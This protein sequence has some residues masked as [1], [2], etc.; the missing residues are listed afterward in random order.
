MKNAS[1]HGSND[2]DSKSGR[3]PSGSHGKNTNR[4]RF[5][6]SSYDDEMNEI[7]QDEGSHINLMNSNYM[8]RQEGPTSQGKSQER[9]TS[10]L[11]NNKKKAAGGIQTYENYQKSPKNIVNHNPKYQKQAE[12]NGSYNSKV[13]DNSLSRSRIQ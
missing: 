13:R 12:L 10:P 9:N 7:N 2:R 8:R 11:R 1:R 4:L 5:R 3:K 6:K